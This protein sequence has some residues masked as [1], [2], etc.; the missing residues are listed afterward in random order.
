MQFPAKV[1]AYI[2]ASKFKR[3][4]IPAVAQQSVTTHVMHTLL[5]N[6]VQ[7]KYEQRVPSGDMYDNMIQLLSGEQQSLME[8][9]YTKQQQKQKQEQKNKNQDS[10]TTDVI[11]RRNQMELNF[12][13]DNHFQ[14][15]LS[16]QAD[17]LKFA[18]SLPIAVPIPTL[19]YT[20]ENGKEY[21]I[22]STQPSNFFT[23]TT[24]KVNISRKRWKIY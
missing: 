10:D 18:L 9:S 5:H 2:L 15:T 7:Q 14:Y 4:S 16:S 19:T 21:S 24:S 3:S 17:M 13:T 8:I 12:E 20:L 1:L 6:I 11:N 22:M 23:R